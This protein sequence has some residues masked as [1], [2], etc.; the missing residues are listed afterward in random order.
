MSHS[1]TSVLVV[2]AGPTGLM[3][4]LGLT[5]SGFDVRVIDERSQRLGRSKATTVWPRQLEL[6]RGVGI[7]DT[8][9]GASTRVERVTVSTPQRRLA[10]F[11]LSDL[12]RVVYPFGV[13][14]PQP[15]LE[16]ILEDRLDSVGVKVERNIR[17]TDLVQ[18]GS[19]VNVYLERTDDSPLRG[20]ADDSEYQ[21]VVGADGAR[22]AVRGLAGLGYEHL[23]GPLTFA[24]TDVPIDGPVPR[25]DVGYYYSD[26]GALGLVPMGAAGFRIAIGVPPDAADV[27]TAGFQAALRRRSGLEGVVVGELPWESHFE[28]LFRHADRY[29]R[30][31]VAIVG[32]AAHTMS[33]AGG[34][35]MNSGLKDAALLTSTLSSVDPGDMS[36]IETAMDFYT[37]QRRRDLRRI[38]RT[39]R[40]LTRFGASDSTTALLQRG[41]LS[42]AVRRS[43]RL[44]QSVTKRIGQLDRRHLRLAV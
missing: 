17:L 28:V 5:H 23:G 15:N 7:A 32:D 27:G 9:I 38:M 3:T 11:E 10:T 18:T 24:I 36:A 2:G 14:I 21:F 6:F 37:R 34:Q 30:G 41:L 31:R 1:R 33:P 4:A 19:G 35:G 26:D 42:Q 29:A 44:R 43:P 13:S 12:Q 16:A 40:L 25:H 8:V 22:S 20:S 39:S